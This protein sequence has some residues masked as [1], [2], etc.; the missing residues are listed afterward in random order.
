MAK[1]P[2]KIPRATS[3]ET[4]VTSTNPVLNPLGAL[5]GET[6]HA[7][8]SGTT[9]NP[10]SDA[11]SPHASPNA[12][13][14]RP[15]VII[16]PALSRESQLGLSR[17]AE[18]VRQHSIEVQPSAHAGTSMSEAPPQPVFINTESASQLKLQVSTAEG[19]RYDKHKKAYVEMHGGMVMVG[20]TLDGWRQT[21]AG[22]STP[23]GERVE[24][25]P[26]TRLWREL[27]ATQQGPH[28][29]TDPGRRPG[30]DEHAYAAINASTLV[31]QLFSRQNVALDLSA[32]QWKNWGKTI[33]PDSGESIE[34]DGQHY[35]IIAQGL[36]ADTGLVYLQHP[37]F[38]PDS[39][40]AFENMLRHEPSRQ[41][42]WAL[43]HQ[44]QW[45][46]LDNHPPFAM[47]ATQYVST[48][49]NYLSEHST[50]NLARAVFDRVSLP[51]GVNAHGLSVM[52]LTFRHWIDRVNNE[53]PMHGLSDPL[54]MLAKLPTPPGSLAGG[55]L[56]TLPAH[57]SVGLQRLDFNPKR[58]PQEW[59][60]YAAAPTAGSL[61]ALLV[62]VLQHNGYSINPTTR[63]LSEGALIF[64]RS[65]VAAVFVLKLP[66]ITG[67]QVPRT[68]PAGHELTDPAFQSRLS[69]AQ[70]QQ[71]DS[72]LAH[73]EVIYLVGG[74]QQI[75]PDNPTLFIVRE[76]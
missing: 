33:K 9:G 19:F 62:S 11:Y 2:K 68:T 39:Y 51:Q 36:R 41:P 29:V 25:I 43:K 60:V 37:G 55:G 46:V 67:N 22:E 1:P 44:G 20:K 13:A 23:T 63:R 10:L 42:K 69:T 8:P 53:A 66:P 61:R 32:G 3:P 65:G 17:A 64:H 73:T 30:L 26:G 75:S 27:D 34:I 24:Q 6:G 59:A 38:S 28:S 40:D 47:S 15:S 49:Y 18:W 5:P 74:L 21:H 4:S 48:A 72:H 12:A 56:L 31:E 57:D 45:K 50:N 16:R 70:K 76:G 52:A 71:L 54:V 7:E 35:P 58:F 14:A